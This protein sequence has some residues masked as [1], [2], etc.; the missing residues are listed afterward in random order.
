VE[1]HYDLQQMVLEEPYP[2]IADFAE[3]DLL[4]HRIEVAED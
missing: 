4:L 3:L 2:K 1:R